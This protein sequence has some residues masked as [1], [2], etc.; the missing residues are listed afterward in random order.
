[1]GCDRDARFLQGVQHA[2]NA[3]EIRS[4]SAAHVLDA[5]A[6]ARLAS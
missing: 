6:P 5:A 2:V 4:S 3:Q 1:M